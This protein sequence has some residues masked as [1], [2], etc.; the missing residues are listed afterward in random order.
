MSGSEPV[1]AEG[2]SRE[3]KHIKK[4]EAPDAAA[5]VMEANRVI[6]EERRDA[7]RRIAAEKDRARQEIE[8]ARAEADRKLADMT[9]E[10]RVL[11]RTIASL[12]IEKEGLERDIVLVKAKLEAIDW[13]RQGYMP[14]VP[15][16]PAPHADA[17]PGSMQVSPMPADGLPSAPGTMFRVTA[18]PSP[19]A[20]EQHRRT[21]S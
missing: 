11:L 2:M 12:Q 1:S 10:R 16:G 6:Q 14:H 7:Q 21:Q 8:R 3:G 9:A 20:A 13:V 5:E 4:V 18:V 19:A 17:A 15:Q